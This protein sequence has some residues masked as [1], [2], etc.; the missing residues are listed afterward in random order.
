SSWKSGRFD[1]VLDGIRSTARSSCVF[2]SG[3]SKTAEYCI[4]VCCKYRKPVSVVG[5]VL[6]VTSHVVNVGVRCWEGVSG[7]A[8]VSP[9]LFSL[10]SRCGVF[11]PDALSLPPFVSK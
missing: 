8:G 5:G 7:D 1:V 10:D 2:L 3:N 6:L 4:Y 9:C 11:D